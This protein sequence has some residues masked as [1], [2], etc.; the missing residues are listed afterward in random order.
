MARILAALGC[1]LAALALCSAAAAD[2]TVGV[3]DDRGKYAEDGGSGFFSQLRDIGMTSNRVTVL[4]DPDRPTTIADRA[5]L[6]RSLPQAAA[7]GVGVVFSVYPARAAAIAATPG[8][9]AQFTQFLQLLAR[10]YPQ[11]REFIVGNE[12]N[13]PRF[14]QPQFN[15]DGSPASAAAYQDLLARSY[16]AL[17]AVDPAI[18]VVGVGLSE[19]GNDNPRAPSN[20]STSPIRFLR[21]LGAAYRAS[22]RT[23]PLMDEL[24]LHPY[25][26]SPADPMLKAYAWPSAGV[27]NIDRIK[28]AVWDAFNG[29]AQP[30][31][32]DGLTLRIS[33]IGWQVAVTPS[34]AGAYTG[35][36]T[37][38]VTDEARQAS[39][40]GE[41]VRH[42]AC[43]P[44]VSS[45]FFFGL[46]DE[47]PLDRFQAGLMRADGTR[48]ASYDAVK[49]ALA[50]TGGRCGGAPRHWRHATTVVDAG[51]EFGNL[52][53]ARSP[54]QRAWGFSVTAGEG[55][56]YRAGIVRLA[57]PRGIAPAELSRALQGPRARTVV[58][59][60]EGAITAHWRPR[61]SFP[62][63]R[64]AP[65]HYVYAVSIAAE[66]NPG[67]T[68][69]FAGTPFRVGAPPKK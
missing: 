48:R 37:V 3:S 57:S 52:R 26:E 23:A 28:Q 67:R 63:R 47:S 69:F 6:D 59:R 65:G 49:E 7:R 20:V 68:S 19:R 1:A 14:W 22:G 60:A 8:S 42:V 33:E 35:A 58:A 18:R 44:A 17:K 12:P 64:L 10:T 39:I 36:E 29:T 5:F 34:A 30:T 24:A 55:A 53:A 9:S 41:L 21:N 27:A 15:P 66:M 25:P 62:S 56:T 11:V 46:V 2:I 61:I 51:A 43:D 16:D 32:E 4:W 31:V 40:Y 54:K 45:L 13:Q 38:A 50:A